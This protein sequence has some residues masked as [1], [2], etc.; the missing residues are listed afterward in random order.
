MRLRLLIHPIRPESVQIRPAPRWLRRVWGKGIRAMTIRHRV[1]VEP[2][3]L[4]GQ[5]RKDALLLVHELVH[6]RQWHDLGV[7]GFL[8]RYLSDYLRGRLK[9]LDHRKA[10]LE[11]SLEREARRLAAL[12]EGTVEG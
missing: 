9:G 11:I 12:F 7:F 8:W 6:V 1:Y 4:T 5:T 3:L 10:Y 2:D